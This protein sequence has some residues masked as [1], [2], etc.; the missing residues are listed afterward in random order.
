MRYAQLRTSTPL[1]VRLA[2]AF[3]Y[4]KAL[5][6][7][8][9][10]YSG[11]NPSDC[12]RDLTSWSKRSLDEP[13]H[14]SGPP[15]SIAEREEQ[16]RLTK[17]A[18]RPGEGR[19]PRLWYAG[20][21]PHRGGWTRTATNTGKPAE[22]TSL[23]AMPTFWALKL[24]PEAEAKCPGLGRRAATP[25]SPTVLSAGKPLCGSYRRMPL[26]VREGRQMRT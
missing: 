21:A 17:D 25:G 12:S 14:A 13:V 2:I 5:A 7:R 6:P 24:Y 26:R 8:L 22:W 18:P 3:H 9:S 16:C 23:R 11:S 15:L 4:G 10:I 19:D 20:F 1:T